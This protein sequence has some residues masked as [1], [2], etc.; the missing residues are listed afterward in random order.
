MAILDDLGL[1]IIAA[2]SFSR[3]LRLAYAGPVVR[4][5]DSLSAEADFYPNGSGGLAQGSA[6]GDDPN[7]WGTA[8]FDVITVYDQSGNALDADTLISASYPDLNLALTGGFA[9]MESE[10]LRSTLNLSAS[11]VSNSTSHILAA[12]VQYNGTEAFG[13]NGGNVLGQSA[14]SIAGLRY[15]AYSGT[16]GVFDPR[17]I[18]YQADDIYQAPGTD[19]IDQGERVSLAL[20]KPTAGSSSADIEGYFEGVLDGGNSGGVWDIRSNF[21]LDLSGSQA[22][23]QL[24]PLFE[25]VW[26]QSA[27]DLIQ[28]D[29][30]A[31]IADQMAYY[32]TR[33]Y[34]PAA[35]GTSLGT[36]I[37]TD[38]APPISAARVSTLGAAQETDAA[39][40]LASARRRTL[41]PAAE[42]D[43]ALP[44]SVARVRSLGVAAE[45]EAAL[46]LATA[47]GVTLAS[48]T[49][50]ETALPLAAE[51]VRSLGLATTSIEALALSTAHACT[52]TPAIEAI[53]ILPITGRRITTLDIAEGS[54][55][56][57]ALVQAAGDDFIRFTIELA[58]VRSIAEIGPIRATIERAA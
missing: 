42:V 30:D 15:E 16:A 2:Y 19:F 5:R 56:A 25:A 6:V 57:L 18:D 22:S 11:G 29:I 44:L 55:Q 23:D 48:V 41:T 10:G 13:N 33:D 20:V 31:L 51:R 27:S 37:E 53:Q 14:G 45:T 1:D 28:A 24:S 39:L 49:M 52:L 38:S 50:A 32:E 7:T 21:K 34:G 58:P 3:Y 12:V 46:P 43:Q 9:A 40:S 47:A 4:L 36:A 8:P 54:D 17:Y 35:A 26:L